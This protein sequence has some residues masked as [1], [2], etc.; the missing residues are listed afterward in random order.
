MTSHA[1]ARPTLPS[2]PLTAYR[3]K[4]SFDW[5]ELKQ[6]LE[7]PYLTSVQK[8]YDLLQK[9]PLFHPE[10]EE[11]LDRQEQ[12]ERAIRQC[13]RIVEYGLTDD[14]KM[15]PFK[16]VRMMTA[17]RNASWGGYTILSLHGIFSNTVERLGSERHKR[18][19]ADSEEVKNFTILGCFALTELSHGTNTRNM[20]T[21]ATYDKETEEFI[22]HTP[23][24]EAAK[25]WVGNLGKHCT[26]A[27]VAAQLVLDGKSLGL[28]WFIVQIRDI[29]THLPMC[30]VTVGD[31]GPKPGWNFEDNGFVMFNHVRIPRENMLN[32]YQDV[33]ADGQYVVK[34]DNPRKRFALTLGSLSGGRVGIAHGAVE[35]AK[36][37]LTISIRYSAV[38]RQFGP[39]KSEEESPVLEY[40]LQQYRLVGA[41][42]GVFGMHFY[43]EWLYH[44]YI[45]VERKS[46]A[47]PPDV[48]DWFLAMNAEMHALS[49]GAKAVT[50]WYARD[51]IQQ[52][53]EC[54]GGHGYSAFSRLGELRES[55]D[56]SLTYEGDNHVL[57][58]QVARFLMKVLNNAQKGKETLSPFGSVTYFKDISAWF[59]RKGADV[60]SGE[61]LRARA[62]A[63][64]QWRAVFLTVEAGKKAMAVHAATS[65]PWHA[66]N[67][68]QVY[69]MQGAARAHMEQAIVARFQEAVN[70]APASLKPI[71]Q[72]MCDLY[73]L[74]C[75]ELNMATFLEGGYFQPSQVPLV[76]ETVLQ[77]I[78][79]LKDD[80]VA[81]VDAIAVP[82]NI[83]WSA[84]GQSNGEA[85]K[86]YFNKVKT[87][88]YT[89]ERP[90]YWRLLR[91]PIVPASLKYKANL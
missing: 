60:A 27:V 71:L 63:A 36:M 3:K 85:Y 59:G 23:D 57:M 21:V 86:N 77:L 78:H 70:S 13:R 55:H 69:Y 34:V 5:W 82:D 58:M 83:L 37:A 39:P 72:T 56:P 28:H 53:R 32:K 26:H 68:S 10:Y 2:G 31:I 47:D 91:E 51:I 48:S 19:F 66:F 11:E 43:T 89:F 41:L 46:R 24:E 61:G 73:A 74:N 87:A 75:I 64:L 35:V 17:I 6:H 54:C 90:S 88:K 40:Q 25:W 16:G 45:Q 22:I 18:F 20:R 9:D 65:S 30:G 42:A 49:C 14:F 80:A 15:D 81:L 84:L 50:T 76:K 33:T 38:R 79:S 8:L 67:D 29:H 1:A 44:Q 62:A 7:G 52:S 4:A 12:R